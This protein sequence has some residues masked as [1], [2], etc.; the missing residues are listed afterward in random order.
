[1]SVATTFVELILRW[2]G[3]IASLD[4]AAHRDPLTGVANRRAFFDQLD[5]PGTGG[6]LLYCDLDHFKP[7]ND[8]LGHAAGDELLQQVAGRLVECAGE[9]RTVARLGGDEFAVLCPDTTSEARR[10]LHRSVRPSRGRSSSPG[11]EVEVGISIGVAHAAD[12][13]RRP[14]TAV[15]HAA[16]PPGAT[17]PRPSGA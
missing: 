15:R 2:S 8:R 5:Q 9:D 7:V 14:S 12:D 1:M 3:Q 17:V 13:A 4:A 11:S 6:A 10:G 16:R